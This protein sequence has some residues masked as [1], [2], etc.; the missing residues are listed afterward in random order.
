MALTKSFRETV[1]ERTKADPEFRKELLYHAVEL[2]LSGDQEAGKRTLRNY[3]NATVGFVA[4]AAEL[5]LSPKGI[6]RMF[7]KTGNPQAN[8]L[9]RIVAYLQVV[10]G[11]E[12][13]VMA[14]SCV[15]RDARRPASKAS[16]F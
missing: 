16:R 2:M 6:Q 10:E 13:K 15:R 14:Q 5:G 12:L 1:V 8:N 3:I 7:G 11:V 9:F 4:L